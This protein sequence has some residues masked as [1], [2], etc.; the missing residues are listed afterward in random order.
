MAD[1]QQSPSE[2]SIVGQRD[3]TLLKKAIIDIEEGN[4]TEIK[5]YGSQQNKRASFFLNLVCV[6]AASP[7]HIP[8]AWFRW[9]AIR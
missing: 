8:R 9:K 5:R 3:T 1:V 4:A 2:E 7:A 6:K